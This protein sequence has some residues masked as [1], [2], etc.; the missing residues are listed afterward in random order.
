MYYNNLLTIPETKFSSIPRR[1]PLTA[2]A[3]VF[4]VGHHTYWSQFPGLLDELDGK[5][6]IFC[7]KIKRFGAEPVD[8]GIVDN[9]S[10][11]LEI[12][13]KLK[14]ADLDILFVDMLTYAT[15]STIGVIFRGL[16]IPI[17]LVALQPESAMDYVHGTTYRQL[18]NDDF[19]SVP[20]FLGVA[21][22][23]GRKIPEVILGT[24]EDDPIADTE[25]AEWC[26]IAHVLHDLRRA[27]LGHLGHV[28]ESMLDMHTDPTALTTTFGVHVVQCEPDQIFQFYRDEYSE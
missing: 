1:K 22:R 14:A 12:L 13:P 25:I 15:S 26:R 20:E 8:F 2:K 21:L 24:L 10:D 7:N 9:A 18:C 11:A 23:M 28:L 6:K 19:C 4:G 5:L 16:D 17:V 27:R 3:G